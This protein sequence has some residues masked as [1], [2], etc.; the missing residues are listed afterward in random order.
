M[1][2]RIYFIRHAR[3]DIPFGERWCVGSRTDLPLGTFGR[4]QASLLA[5]EPELKGLNTVFCSN[6]SRSRETALV[7]SAAPETQ[8]GLEEQDMGEWDGLSFTEIKE[9][10][11]ELYAVRETDPYTLPEGS[12]T[13]EHMVARFKEAVDRCIA[14]SEGDIAIVAHKSCISTI[15]GNREMLGWTSVSTTE[16]DSGILK[17]TGI[18]RQPH[19][20]LTDAICERMIFAAGAGEDIIAHCRAVADLAE[21]LAEALGAKGLRLDAKLI[22]SSALLHDIARSEKDHPSAGAKWLSELG[23]PAIA[24]IIRQHHDPDSTSI[25]ETSVVFIA[26]K[27]VKGSERISIED[28]FEASLHKCRT[29]D[30]L[31]AHTRRLKAAI[32]IKEK[33]NSLCG[34]K[35]L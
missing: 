33:I 32:T 19:P 20:E 34:A 31:E 5:F 4:I 6:L 18:G 35:L 3:P 27:A 9:C 8:P 30:A 2:R 14:A 12:E 23:Y 21:Q 10:W 26:D 22:R 1:N 16:Y 28:R 15:T 11:P 29:K 7:L 25:N 17:V 13:F 24:D